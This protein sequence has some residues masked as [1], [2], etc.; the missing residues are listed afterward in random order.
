ME[1]SPKDQQIRKILDVIDSNPNLKSQVEEL[2]GC[3]IPN[4]T[5]AGRPWLP[6]WGSHELR[7]AVRGGVLVVFVA[8]TSILITCAILAALSEPPED[9][10][11]YEAYEGEDDPAP[12]VAP[13]SLSRCSSFSP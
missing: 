6:G 5:A 2:A 8:V 4:T 10:H 9:C 11:Q 13:A 1:A 7:G 12:G 3:E